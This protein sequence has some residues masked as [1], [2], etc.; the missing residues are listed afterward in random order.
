MSST[1][2]QIIDLAVNSNKII[3]PEAAQQI[4]DLQTALDERKAYAESIVIR[5]QE[6]ANLVRENAYNTSIKKAHDEQNELLAKCEIKINHMYDKLETDIQ[7]V[8]TRVL[9]N[10]GFT[11]PTS[12]NVQEIINQEI[13]HIKQSDAILKIT[14]NNKVM[15]HIKNVMPSTS[16]QPIFDFDEELSD[17]ECILETNWYVFRLNLQDAIKQINN[18]VPLLMD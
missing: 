5:A 1:N 15:E 14:C 3:T 4:F 11:N 12:Q 16:T 6:Q 18:L 10:F 7:N 9:L 17:D 13:K 2:P 8:V